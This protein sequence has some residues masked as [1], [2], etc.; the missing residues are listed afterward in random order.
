MER[1]LKTRRN[2]AWRMKAKRNR[3]C[4]TLGWVRDEKSIGIY[5]NHGLGLCSSPICMACRN[6]HK[7][8]GN[9]NVGKSHAEKVQESRFKDQV[10]NWDA[11][12][13]ES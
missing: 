7:I 6:P 3:Q 4:K 9:S 13:E 5:A 1:N 8:Y 2:H 11:D 12:G 10:R